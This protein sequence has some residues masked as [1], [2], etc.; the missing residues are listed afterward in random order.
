MSLWGLV[1]RA[2][3]ELDAN[4]R[5]YLMQLHIYIDSG[6]SNRICCNFGRWFS[7]HLGSCRAWR[8]QFRS[9]RAA[10]GCAADAGDTSRIRCDFGR[11]FSSHLCRLW[12]WQ[13]RSSRSAQGCAADS[14]DAGGS[15]CN[16][17]RWLSSH[18]GSC[19]S[20]RWHFRS[21]SSWGEVINCGDSWAGLDELRFP[22]FSLGVCAKILNRGLVYQNK[23]RR[24]IKRWDCSRFV[25]AESSVPK[26]RRG[27]VTS[28]HI[29]LWISEIWVAGINPVACK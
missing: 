11:W 15:C 13:F 23:G 12:R 17:G 26:L 10:W 5:R 18:L 8:R 9:S 20:W 7:S 25:L 14:G 1:L 19:R 2:V 16:F 3:F 27:L 24:G 22:C 6:D 29:T 21:S 4:Q 28:R